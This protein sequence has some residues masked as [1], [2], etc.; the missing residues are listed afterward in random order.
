MGMDGG[1]SD[2]MGAG[3]KLA[4]CSGLTENAVLPLRTLDCSMAFFLVF[5]LTF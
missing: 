4:S 2:W 5:P 3:R 1:D